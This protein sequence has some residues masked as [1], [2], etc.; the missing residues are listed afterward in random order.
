[1]NKLTEGLVEDVSLQLLFA[2]LEAV[3]FL[4]DLF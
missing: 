1:M 3:A 2:F 4:L